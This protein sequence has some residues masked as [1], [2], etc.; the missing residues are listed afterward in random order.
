MH[1]SNVL[2]EPQVAD[3]G[4]HRLAIFNA[5]GMFVRSLGANDNGQGR[6]H[7][8]VCVA[9]H[10]SMGIVYVSDAQSQLLHSLPLQ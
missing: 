1:V 9:V 6:L 5:A 7:M 8:P 3:T 4:H 2:E 10:A